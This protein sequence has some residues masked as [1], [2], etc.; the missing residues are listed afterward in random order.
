MPIVT[1]NGDIVIGQISGIFLN[2]DTGVVEGFF[3]QTGGMFGAEDLFLASQDIRH[4]GTRVRIL[5]EDMLSPPEER[6]R[7]EAIAAENRPL[8]GQ[9]IVT[10]S[11]TRLGRCRDV[12]FETKTFRLEWLFPRGWLRWRLP[13]PVSAIIEVKK[14]AVIVRDAFAGE[15]PGV[16]KVIDELTESSVPRMPEAG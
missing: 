2:P 6:V 10:K 7:L 5:S 16:L 9:T 13:V 12:Q 14:E 15:R 3:V 11:G 1:E 8:L 4:W